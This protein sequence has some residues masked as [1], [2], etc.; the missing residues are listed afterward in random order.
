MSLLDDP[1]TEPTL[2]ALS[3]ITDDAANSGR[4]AVFD[5]DGTIIDTDI[6]ETVASTAWRTGD[7]DTEPF[8][9]ALGLQ[10]AADGPQRQ[11]EAF[12]TYLQIADSDTVDGYPFGHQAS[13]SLLAQ[14]F[15]GKS[16]G[17][18]I[19]STRA[20]LSPGEGVRVR[21]AIIELLRALLSSGIQV[22]VVSAGLSWCVRT[23]LHEIVNPLLQDCGVVEPECVTGITPLMRVGQ[24]WL[25]DRQMLAGPRAS[26][27]GACEDA[28]LD[29]VISTAA[30]TGPYTFGGGKVGAWREAFGEEV[31]VLM[32][33][34][35]AGDGPLMREADH[36]LWIRT[37]ARQ[38]RPAA[39]PESAL[40]L[41]A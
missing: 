14:A 1:W 7:L 3:S 22:R 28:D 5:F 20:V 2:Q 16:V 34:D 40:V 29:D 31:P 26:A 33:G 8:W 24:G 27:Y 21:P 9:W 4:I 41:D 39:I 30:I 17:Q 37:D 19:R 23:A 25:T 18:V 15:A 13:S 32:V 10:T 36:A 38:P 6:T 11:R 35:G 12:E